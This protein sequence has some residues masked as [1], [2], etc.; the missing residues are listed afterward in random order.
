MHCF[1]GC[2]PSGYG[3]DFL[4]VKAKKD[5]LPDRSSIFRK[6]YSIAGEIAE[7]SRCA[8]QTRGYFYVLLE[9][10]HENP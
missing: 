5:P 9:H 1:T 2:Y 10:R 4:D 6:S 8:I 3:A 7:R